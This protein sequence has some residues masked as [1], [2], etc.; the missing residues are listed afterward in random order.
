[1][2]G[3]AAVARADA[4]HRVERAGRRLQRA[5]AAGEGDDD[6]GDPA[7]MVA[8]AST[9]VLPEG[10]QMLVDEGS[11]YPMYFCEATGE[12][13]WEPPD[14]A[15]DA[16]ATPPTAQREPQAPRPGALT[17]GHCEPWTGLPTNPPGPTK[18]QSCDSPS[19]QTTT[20]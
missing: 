7:E 5:P 6:Y 9:L 10:W 3:Y 4:D 14:G 18:K 20:R 19:A 2:P 17:R 15:V 11:G 12:T 8:R 1:M 13:Q 16:A